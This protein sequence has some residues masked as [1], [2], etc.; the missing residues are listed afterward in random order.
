MSKKLKVAVALALC[1]ALLVPNFIFASAAGGNTTTNGSDG[2][3]IIPVQGYID[4]N[5]AVIDPTTE[6]YVE[7]PVEILFAAFESDA[8]AVTSPRYTIT[9]LS[10]V[11][12]VKVEI[13]NFTQRDDPAASLNGQLS[14]KLVDYDG[15][16][17][18][19]DMFPNDYQTA[20]LLTGHLAAAD[21]SGANKLGFTVGGTWDG[22]F[23]E[24]LYPEF[25][26]TLK[27]SAA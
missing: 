2:N 8:G 16:D 11:S 22:S 27:F 6:I 15:N 25:D 14:L 19:T 4:S 26:M 1:M 5:E 3:Q 24:R 13:L 17:L 18:A 23:A 9:N 20:K 10:E 12:G 21:G 7:V